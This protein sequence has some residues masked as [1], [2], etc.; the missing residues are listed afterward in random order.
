F[1]IDRRVIPEEDPAEVEAELRTLIANAAKHDPQIKVEMRRLLLAE[2][3]APRPATQR[4]AAAIQRRAKE[5]L[6]VEVPVAGV[7]LYTDARHYAAAGIPIV[8]YGAGPRSLGEAN[9][10]NANENLGLNDL[11]AATKIVAMAVADL[12]MK[13]W[14]P[15]QRRLEGAGDRFFT[16]ARDGGIADRNDDLARLGQLS[17]AIGGCAA[18]LAIEPF[19]QSRI[20]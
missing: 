3:L 19:P 16:L 8:L 10:H 18:A 11:R 13:E 7:P 20:G 17:K 9:A 1:R 4:I 2:P 12:L 5:V 14:S 15:N 6:R